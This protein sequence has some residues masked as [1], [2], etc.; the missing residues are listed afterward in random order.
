MTV[1]RQVDRHQVRVLG[2]RRRDLLEREQT[3]HHA[4]ARYLRIE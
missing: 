1:A 4:I 2:E 3:L